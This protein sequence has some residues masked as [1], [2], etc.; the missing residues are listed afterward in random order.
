MAALASGLERS[1]D[2][3]L[4]HRDT[5]GSFEGCRCEEINSA[6]ERDNETDA[7]LSATDQ[8]SLIFQVERHA[9]L[10]LHFR[11]ILQ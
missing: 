3:Q 5:Q 8:F 11:R 6:G 2:S 7:L 10:D 4:R 1:S 9:K